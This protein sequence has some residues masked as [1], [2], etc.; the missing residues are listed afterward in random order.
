[1]AIN[2]AHIVSHYAQPKPRGFQ[3]NPRPLKL[4]KSYPVPS[5]PRIP[6]A[7]SSPDAP[8]PVV[9][10]QNEQQEESIPVEE[11][12]PDV[13]ESQPEESQVETA[14]SNNTT[15]PLSINSELVAEPGVSPEDFLRNALPSTHTF[16]QPT[17]THTPMV[18]P[19]HSRLDLS[20]PHRLRPSSSMSNISSTSNRS[21]PPSAMSVSGRTRRSSSRTSLRQSTAP[22]VGAGSS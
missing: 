18:T 6:S 11:A 2:T 4:A 8:Q 15:S 14:S 20:P 19:S 17:P 5:R 1:M 12:K 22:S 16:S 10:V 13:S 7:Q 21:R 3:W 9:R